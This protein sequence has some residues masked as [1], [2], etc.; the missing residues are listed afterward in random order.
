MK[1][2]SGAMESSL[3]VD[4]GVELVSYCCPSWTAFGSDSRVPCQCLLLRGTFA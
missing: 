2:W 1:S 3:G 4:F